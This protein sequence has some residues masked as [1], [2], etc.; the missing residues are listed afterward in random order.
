VVFQADYDEI[1]LQKYGYDVITIKSPKN[2]IKITSQIFFPIW[3]SRLTKNFGY[4]SA[5]ASP[6][7][8]SGINHVVVKNSESRE[9]EL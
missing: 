9:R 6:M 3:A 2:V 4:A 7:D 5:L 8:A 1:K